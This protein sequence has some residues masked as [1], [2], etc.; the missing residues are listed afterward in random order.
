MKMAQS[1][2][3]S[4]AD[5]R[6]RNLD[7]EVRDW[8]YRKV[9]PMRGVTRFGIKGNLNLRYVETYEI[10]EKVETVAYHLD[11]PTEFYGIYNMFHMSSLRKSLGAQTQEVVDPEGISL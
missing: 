8:I 2:Q 10:L 7:F 1:R 6:R 11:L 9:S 5:N 4:Y 3:K